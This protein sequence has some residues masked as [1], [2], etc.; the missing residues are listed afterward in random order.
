MKQCFSCGEINSKK[1]WVCP[2]LFSEQ[3]KEKLKFNYITQPRYYNETK[4]L[5][6]IKSYGGTKKK[7]KQE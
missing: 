6:I 3:E 5:Q 4:A 1:N 2:C 7:E